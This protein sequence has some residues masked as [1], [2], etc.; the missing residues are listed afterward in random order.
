MQVLEQILE[1]I[2]RRINVLNAKAGK[3]EDLGRNAEADKIDCE[4]KGLHTATSIIRSR[5]DDEPVS[6]TDRLD[7]GWIP[8][9]SGLP[10]DKADSDY[11]ES[12]IVTLLNG[13]V[14]PGVYRNNEKEWWVEGENG[15]K[16]Y[17]CENRVIA[18]KPLPQPYQQK[19]G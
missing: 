7:D 15:S 4:I 8:V 19:E 11:Y 6:N 3:Y 18:W 14:S 9:E 1:G 13:R 10:E 17:V 16:E 12:V 2:N 5:M